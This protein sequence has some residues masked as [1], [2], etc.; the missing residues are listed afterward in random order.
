MKVAIS[1]CLNCGKMQP[2]D[3]KKK[4]LLFY[5]SGITPLSIVIWFNKSRYPCKKSQIKI[6][7]KGGGEIMLRCYV[8]NPKMKWRSERNT[9]RLLL[10]LSCEKFTWKAKRCQ[11]NNYAVFDSA[12]HTKHSSLFVYWKMS[13][14]FIDLNT[15][16]CLT[17]FFKQLKTIPYCSNMPYV[18][19]TYVFSV[20][21]VINSV[22]STMYLR[23]GWLTSQ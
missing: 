12:F 17:Y 13:K 2:E 1:G 3:T 18:R 22:T 7:K 8:I 20:P 19:A 14:I 21:D 9:F 10:C 5:I 11:L 15:C 16:A 4:E 23:F 6:I